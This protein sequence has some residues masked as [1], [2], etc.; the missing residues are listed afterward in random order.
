MGSE[1]SLNPVDHSLAHCRVCRANVATLD[2]ELIHALGK[3]PSG[4]ER[5]ICPLDYF[6]LHRRA[7]D[8]Q[9]EREKESDVLVAV[10][11]A[12]LPSP[13]QSAAY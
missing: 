11:R 4:R 10:G 9:K 1:I 7:G 6:P 8:S 2:L 13:A 3:T 5:T 12:L